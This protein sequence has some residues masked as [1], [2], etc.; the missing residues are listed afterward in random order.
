MT[1]DKTAGDWFAAKRFGYG[2]GWPIAWQGW[3]VMAAYLGVVVGATVVVP[4]W[5][6]AVIVPATILMAVLC[7]RHTRGGWR[8]RSGG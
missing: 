5:S 1:D 2:S 3:V 4:R 8:W 6:A 7:S